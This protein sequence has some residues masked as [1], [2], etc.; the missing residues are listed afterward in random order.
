MRLAMVTLA[1]DYRI[2]LRLSNRV[3]KKFLRVRNLASQ[4]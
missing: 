3:F 2:H 1:D 4:R